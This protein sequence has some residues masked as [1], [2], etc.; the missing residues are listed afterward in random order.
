MMSSEIPN[1]SLEI[2]VILNCFNDSQYLSRAIDSILA[3]TYQNFEI[4]VLDNAS[5]DET[6]TVLRSIKDPR[7]KV[8]RTQRTLPLSQARNVAINFATASL[9][10]FIDADDFWAPKKLEE[11]I[12]V[13]R[14]GKH[15][16]V[17]TNFTFQEAGVIRGPIFSPKSVIALT[18][19][20][21]L[22]VFYPVAMS[23]ILMDRKF[24][25]G[26][27]FNP[28]TEIIGDFELMT[29]LALNQS[30]VFVESSL[31]TIDRRPTSESSRKAHL[32]A[33]ELF[34][35]AK[36]KKVDSKFRSALILGRALEISLTRVGIVK[37]LSLVNSFKSLIISLLPVLI[38]YAF[39]RALVLVKRGGKL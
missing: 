28:E 17:C 18:K 19:V 15:S 1:N 12:K 6:Q 31:A 13:M 35:L 33:A 30:W 25:S 10:A 9:L 5:T 8:H 14:T 16:F 36:R 23:T 22:E 3:Q 32:M 24:F 21:P 2:S 20:V 39:Y 37:T 4:I 7:L 26:D 34:G 29:S 27:I 11:Q 38:T